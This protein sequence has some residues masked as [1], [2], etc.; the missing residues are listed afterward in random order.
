MQPVVVLVVMVF[1]III[2]RVILAIRV[3]NS[4]PN[5]ITVSLAFV[6]VGSDSG[7]RAIP[8]RHFVFTFRAKID[9][10]QPCPT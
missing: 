6:I 2:S 1:A 5:F 4:P 8:R 9:L 7:L 10:S 3:N